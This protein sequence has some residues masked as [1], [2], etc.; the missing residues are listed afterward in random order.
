MNQYIRPVWAAV[1]TAFFF[2]CGH[3]YAGRAARYFWPLLGLLIVYV[4]A[5]VFG[6]LS[7][8]VVFAPLT[9]AYFG[10]FFFTLGDAYDLV[11]KGKSTVQWYSRWYVC[12]LWAFIA[13]S[14]QVFNDHIRARYLGYMAFVYPDPSGMMAPAVMYTDRLLVDTWAYKSELPKPG[15]VVAVQDLEQGLAYIRRVAIVND[16]EMQFKCDNAGIAGPCLDIGSHPPSAVIG[17][18][19]SVF[20]SRDISRI[21][22]AVK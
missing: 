8:L 6:T 15:D 7:N 20:F 3:L 19:K 16:K 10:F 18:V 14:Y 2:G 11:R 12:V 13:L 9:I 4:V 22:R 21:G 17:R 1:L 5:G